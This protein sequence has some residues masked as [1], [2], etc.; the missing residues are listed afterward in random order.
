VKKEQISYYKSFTNKYKRNI[1]TLALLGTVGL[2]LLDSILGIYF[3]GI[4]LIAL[5]IIL[6]QY[7][8]W[9]SLTL[10]QFIDIVGG[11]EEYQALNADYLDPVYEDKRIIIGTKYVIKKELQMTFKQ[12]PSRIMLPLD[13]ICWVYQTITTHRVYGIPTG[14]SYTL[15]LCSYQGQIVVGQKKPEDTTVLDVLY[16]QTQNFVFG[17]SPER[18]TTFRNAHSKE[19]FFNELAIIEQWGQQEEQ[20]NESENENGGA[21]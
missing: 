2:F 10:D 13:A 12:S 3:S 15:N 11:A 20:I 16:K 9:A 5:T 6:F 21:V 7:T 8:R 1:V 19:T 14:K 18:A 4:A 17:Y